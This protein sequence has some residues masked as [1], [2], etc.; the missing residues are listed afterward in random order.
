MPR[1]KLSN[2]AKYAL[3]IG[4]FIFLTLLWWV[5]YTGP[6][7]WI[8]ELQVS[9]LGS[10]EV[11]IT[12]IVVLLIHVLVGAALLEIPAVKRYFGTQPPD[13][14]RFARL[15]GEDTIIP[16]WPLFIGTVTLGSGLFLMTEVWVAGEL[17]SM[18]IEELESGK[19][20]TSGWISVKGVLLAGEMAQLHEGTPKDKVGSYVPMVSQNWKRGKPVSVYFDLGKEK[21]AT[22]GEA[23]VSGRVSWMGLPGVIREQYRRSSAPPA[24]GYLMLVNKY[25]PDFNRG[26]ARILFWIGGIA[27]AIAVVLFLLY[28]RAVRKAQQRRMR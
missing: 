9:L 27:Y 11:Q 3:A 18:T 28:W 26:F 22:S 12:L 24:D 14:C 6:F 23:T 17:T 15:F 8:A 2:E 21:T 4:L 7:Q 16:W 20:P 10:Y 1:L 13:W 25:D 5:T 19:R